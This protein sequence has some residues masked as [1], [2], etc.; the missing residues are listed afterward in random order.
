MK[1]KKLKHN[2]FDKRYLLLY[3]FVITILLSYKFLTK[4]T[5]KLAYFLSR[6]HLEVALDFLFLVAVWLAIFFI[7]FL[8]NSLIKERFK[9]LVFWVIGV[10]SALF[11]IINSKILT[12]IFIPSL[13]PDQ[14]P[15]KYLKFKD[16]IYAHTLQ[17]IPD[18]IQGSIESAL[19][20]AVIALLICASF[21]LVKKHK[22][23]IIIFASIVCLMMVSTLGKYHNTR[24]ANAELNINAKI[25]SISANKNIK[26]QT[27][28][29]I[30]FDSFPY[31]AEIFGEGKID[32]KKYPNFYK[33][34]SQSY[35][36]QR[37]RSAGEGTEATFPRVITG[38]MGDP[39]FKNS[40]T[41]FRTEGGQFFLDSTPT[42][43]SLAKKNNDEVYIT[44]WFHEYCHLFGKSATKCSDYSFYLT[45]EEFFQKTAFQKFALRWQVL[46]AGWFASKEK[47]PEGELAP[48]RNIPHAYG[49]GGDLM[50]ARLWVP[51]FKN[52]VSDY[53]SFMKNN[54]KNAF[55]F[56]HLNIPHVPIVFNARGEF[57]AS[58]NNV[59]SYKE[60]LLYMDKVLG[61]LLEDIKKTA[62]YNKSM[63]ILTSDH[64]FR[65]GEVQGLECDQ[66]HVPLAI[67]A[68]NQKQRQNIYDEVSTVSLKRILENYYKARQSGNYS[69]LF[70][71][72][73][74]PQF[75]EERPPVEHLLKPPN[76]NLPE[77]M[78]RGIHETD[79]M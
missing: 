15:S 58:E 23:Q 51:L 76:Q 48:I 9:M 47:G 1:I 71:N 46:K 29:I 60:E 72:I 4:L 53:Q 66:T 52:L 32:A 24:F 40:K 27:V 56:T 8:L 64:G 55:F 69:K 22:K 21:I 3:S 2:I 54:T 61:M 19:T 77:D 6:S 65:G 44:G 38:K 74:P 39:V 18:V 34:L 7:L 12:K 59:K 57:N 31:E 73:E 16:W 42:I 43:F 50:S 33:F 5:P 10:F 28:H 13:Y 37:V 49:G 75:M 70:K 35:V 14:E 45:F 62:N 11:A 79:N 36:F 78:P 20:A 67:K 63:I 30:F 41:Y 68:P 25:K 17:S 26:P